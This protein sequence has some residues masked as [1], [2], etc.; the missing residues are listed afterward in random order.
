[1]KYKF[2]LNATTLPKGGGIQACVSFIYMS[3]QL[4]RDIEWIYIVSSKVEEE[5]L[6]FN[7]DI[8][9]TRL[10]VFNDSPA[11][12]IKSRK[13]LLKL[14][15]D[16]SADCIFTFFGPAYVN[17]TSP[18]LC[19][20]ADGWVT[21]S[22]RLAYQSLDTISSKL[23]TFIRCLYKAFWYRYADKWVVEA[24]CAKK[25]LVKRIRVSE[26]SVYVVKNTCAQHY[27]GKVDKPYEFESDSLKILTLSSYY[28]HKNLT[29]IPYVAQQLKKMGYN[30]FQFI[31]TITQETQ[32][33][34]RILDL[35]E[36]L[37]VTRF[38]KNIGPVSIID[39]PSLYS[40]IDMVLQPSLLETFSAN[41]PE[42]MAKGKPIVTTD[43]DFA[44]DTCGDSALF[45]SSR[46]AKSAAECIAS[47]IDNKDLVT[48]LTS[49]GYKILNKLPSSQ[50]KYYAYESL[51]INMAKKD[52]RD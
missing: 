31:I 13:R 27:I 50:E 47:L 28:P 42:A 45:Y 44:H 20:V 40:A 21:H 51:L 5:L 32:E 33:E 11:K 24:D 29:I 39:G 46:N 9:D 16:L 48:S 26:D 3:L 52:C 30:H 6:K 17:F 41:Y 35:C 38:V 34:S 22:S 25:G 1:M 10:I 23:L 19:G 4:S 7:A 15:E 14:T 2:I 18:H 43:L 8:P 49:K 36:K 37:D 12:N